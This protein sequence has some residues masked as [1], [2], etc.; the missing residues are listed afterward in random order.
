MT[1][2]VQVGV[3]EVIH[4]HEIGRHYGG[5]TFG[6]IKIVDFERCTGAPWMRYVQRTAGGAQSILQESH[7]NRFWM[8]KRHGI[9]VHRRRSARLSHGV[10]VSS[11]QLWGVSPA[12]G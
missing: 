8:L 3:E 11:L 10:T 4:L 6:V 5:Q 7:Y 1:K 12:V 9:E 2:C